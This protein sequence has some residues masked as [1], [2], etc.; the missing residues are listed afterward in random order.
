MNNSLVLFNSILYRH[1]KVMGNRQTT[2]SNI[3]NNNILPT[4]S[5][6]NEPQ[7]DLR[8]NRNKKLGTISTILK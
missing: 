2:H 6:P 1:M 5:S 8:V 4:D 7:N 3:T